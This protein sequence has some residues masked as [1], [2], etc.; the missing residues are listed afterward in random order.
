MA[1]QNPNVQNIMELLKI[2]LSK[3]SAPNKTEQEFN[4]AY[5]TAE[6]AKA[7]QAYNNTWYYDFNWPV[8]SPNKFTGKLKGLIKKIIRKILKFLLQPLIAEQIKFNSSMTWAMNEAIKNLESINQE[9]AE[10]K[11]RE[12][13]LRE[14]GLSEG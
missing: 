2:S 14:K 10:L 9:I 6:L 11:Q 13:Q 3:Q 12:S 8:A 1:E 4:G 5:D 7:A